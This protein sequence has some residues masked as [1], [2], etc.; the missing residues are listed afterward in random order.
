MII[1]ENINNDV[2]IWWRHKSWKRRISKS[3]LLIFAK[4][5]PN[6]HLIILTFSKIFDDVSKNQQFLNFCNYCW[7][8]L[9]KISLRELD[10]GQNYF[11]GIR[12]MHLGAENFFPVN[13]FK[14]ICI[15]S[16]SILNSFSDV[17]ELQHFWNLILLFR[18]ISLEI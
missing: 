8:N 17:L 5:G 9:Q 3:I 15:I 6:I 2:M 1:K 10:I 18:L 4:F 13:I 7:R 16:D 12:K 14:L 11:K